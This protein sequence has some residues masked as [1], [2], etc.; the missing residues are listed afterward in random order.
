MKTDCYVA[1]VKDKWSLILPSELRL[2]LTRH[3]ES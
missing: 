2:N 1:L 3:R